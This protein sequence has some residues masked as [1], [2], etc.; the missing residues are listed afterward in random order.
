LATRWKLTV[1]RDDE[2]KLIEVT[3]TDLQG[4]E[5]GQP[6]AKVSRKLR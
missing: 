1:F 6:L 5:D 3:L 2:S 4:T